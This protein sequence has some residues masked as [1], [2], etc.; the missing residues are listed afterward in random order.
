MD[1]TFNFSI[2]IP[3]FNEEIHIKRC[4]ENAKKLTANVFVV[5]SFSTDQTIELAKNTGAFVFQYEWGPSS[6]FSK[7]NQL[8][9]E[10]SPH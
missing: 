5:D 8:G 10:K 2:I 1:R 4:V 7:K 9:I 6:N 3:T